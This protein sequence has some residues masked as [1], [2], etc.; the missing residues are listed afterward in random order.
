MLFTNTLSIYINPLTN[1][2]WKSVNDVQSVAPDIMY[3][4]QCWTLIV[5]QL[6]NLHVRSNISTS[7]FDYFW[8]I[9][10]T[11]TNNFNYVVLV[12]VHISHNDH[13]VFFLIVQNPI[14]LLATLSLHSEDR[15]HLKPD[16]DGAASLTVIL[17]IFSL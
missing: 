12:H 5:C 8:E 6:R 15:R 16:G 7:Y 2:E 9:L 3:Y 13:F 4:I 14:I 17:V 11:F 1:T 10:A